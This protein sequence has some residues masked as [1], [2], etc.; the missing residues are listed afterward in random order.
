MGA[1]DIVRLVGEK[2]EWCGKMVLWDEATMC[3]WC[4]MYVCGGCYEEHDCEICPVCRV[5]HEKGNC[6]EGE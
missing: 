1:S 6:P 4:E 5:F 2:C 3:A